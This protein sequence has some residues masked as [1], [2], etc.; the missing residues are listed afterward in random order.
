VTC[1]EGEY[2]TTANVCEPC[3][4]FCETCEEL[5]QNCTKCKFDHFKI[6]PSGKVC[7]C[8]IFNSLHT[9]EI[10]GKTRAEDYPCSLE[11]SDKEYLSNEK[12]LELTFS[13]P[14]NSNAA[15][16]ENLKV[17]AKKRNG[18]LATDVTLNLLDTGLSQDGKTLKL[19][20]EI[21][22]Q[23]DEGTIEASPKDPAKPIV[24][25]RWSDLTYKEDEYPI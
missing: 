3:N 17:V 22:G 12:R 16:K 1:P 4:Q 25:S 9:E 7:T 23:L 15:S 21:D 2:R 18:E 20:L 5:T 10:E 14:L 8:P 19:F 13:Q 24:S 11:L 6:H